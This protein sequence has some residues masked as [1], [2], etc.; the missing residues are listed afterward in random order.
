[1]SRAK[2]K[3]PPNVPRSTAVYAFTAADSGR[4][5]VDGP[6]GGSSEVHASRPRAAPENRRRDRMGIILASKERAAQPLQCEQRQ[7]STR[8]SSSGSQAKSRAEG[9]TST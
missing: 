6:V 3:L 1:M 4:V 8:P 2:L 7:H 5:P 9:R